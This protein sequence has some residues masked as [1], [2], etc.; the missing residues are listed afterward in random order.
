LQE[1]LMSTLKL[2]KRVWLKQDLNIGIVTDNN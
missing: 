1:A 2:E